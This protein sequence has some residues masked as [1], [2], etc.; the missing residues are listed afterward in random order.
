MKFSNGLIIP[1][2]FLSA[3]GSLSFLPETT[4]IKPLL[5]LQKTLSAKEN[6]RRNLQEA[7]ISIGWKITC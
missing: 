6:L 3:A 4:K 1:M 2:I 7:R 5:F